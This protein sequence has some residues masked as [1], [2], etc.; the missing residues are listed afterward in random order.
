MIFA[1]CLIIMFILSQLMIIFPI[2]Q[3]MFG[4]ISF[5]QFVVNGSMIFQSGVYSCSEFN[6]GIL[7]IHV[8]SFPCFIFKTILVIHVTSVCA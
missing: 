5:I 7:S 8:Y 4:S 2:F 3:Q 6:V 1:T